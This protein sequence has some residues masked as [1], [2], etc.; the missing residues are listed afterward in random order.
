VLDSL[1]QLGESVIAD[2]SFANS[3]VHI[4]VL[5]LILQ[6]FDACSAA[7]L[8]PGSRALTFFIQALL[9]SDV[10]FDGRSLQL[11]VISQV[12]MIIGSYS[13]NLFKLSLNA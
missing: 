7:E 4:D 5:Q 12:M 11:L 2:G 10:A 8:K 13:S 1:I 3:P 6:R 9:G